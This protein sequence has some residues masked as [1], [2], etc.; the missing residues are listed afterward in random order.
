[1]AR[2]ALQWA[3]HYA[4]ALISFVVAST[5][6]WGDPPVAQ[7]EREGIV[8]ATMAPLR[9]PA[10][11]LM[12]NNPYFSVWS[13]ANRLTDTWPTHWTGKNAAL[14][15]LV[16][17]DGKCYRWCGPEPA[18][19]EAAEQV[20]VKVESLSTTYTFRAGGVELQAVFVSP[21]FA[22][23]PDYASWSGAV[24][25]LGARC[26]DEAEHTVTFYAD[27]SGEWC[28][29]DDSQ[30]VVWSRL[31]GPGAHLLSMG[32]AEQRVLERSGDATRIDWGRM[33]LGVRDKFGVSSVICSD[34]VSREAFAR[35]GVLPAADETDFPR[36][37]R[38]RWPV[39]AVCQQMGRVRPAK[40]VGDAPTHVEMRVVFAYD[41]QR[42]VEYFERPLRPVWAAS[43]QGGSDF[44]AT[45]TEVLR[46]DSELRAAVVTENARIRDAA[47]A[48]GGVKYSAL[49]ELA[50]RQVMGAHGL[51]ADAD[52]TVLMF[53]KENS[54]NG[55]ISTVNVIFSSAPFFLCENPA[56]LEAQ[57]RP[58]LAYAAMKDRWK[59]NFAPHDLGVYPKA[60]G[61]AYGGGEKSEAGQIPVE[62]CGNML[63]LMEAL[64]IADEKRGLA[65]AR[66]YW[67]SLTLWAEYLKVHGFDP[68]DQ[69]GTDSF[70]RPLARNA[71]LSIKAIIGLGAY[72]RLCGA[73]ED[74]A[75]AS[76]WREVATSFAG[77]WAGLAAG[78]SGQTV[79]AFGSGAT[80]SLK[81][82]LFWDHALNLGLFPEKLRADEVTFYLGKVNRYG[83]PLDSRAAYTKLDFLFWAA[84]M[85]PTNAQWEAMTFPAYDYINSSP[86]RVA[87][88]DWY[89]TKTAKVEGFQ[90][91]S[92]VGGLWAKQLLAR[93]GFGGTPGVKQE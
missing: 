78:D 83:T 15:G 68:G 92:V 58:V 73:V 12:V 80:W 81:Y 55:C 43:A 75:R 17:V 60:N 36:P 88:S 25:Y 90:S 38:D 65:L 71:N 31:R 21:C 91:R 42:V 3:M 7:G 56:L 76:E 33:Y 5:S 14:C 2:S 74:E 16:M 9:A 69:V 34:T 24:L 45:V 53:A 61:Q 20:S 70:A 79:L 50:Y 87:M 19:V 28:V 27:V 44:A 32:T 64:R 59:F 63:I 6:A 77:R 72:A 8:N 86:D 82:N 18:G 35:L 49:C 10:V 1:M 51:A 67:P 30:E 52:G 22:G 48:A 37:A 13:P 40:S 47:A 26:A 54:S 85:A 66:A 41:Q 57:L 29:H 84:A 89:D 93:P 62:E 46:D 4:A 11:P 39:L 23:D